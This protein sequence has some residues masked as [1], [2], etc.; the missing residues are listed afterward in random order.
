[1]K[2]AGGAERFIEQIVI[3][4]QGVGSTT[5]ALK[6][7]VLG[8]MAGKFSRL[9]GGAFGDGLEDSIV[10]TYLRLAFNYEA[11]DEIYIFGFSRGAYAVR[12]L[13]GFI[14]S[15]GIVSRRFTEK[16]WM[17][18]ALYRSAP[19]EGASEA[20][21]EAHRHATE[22]FRMLYGKGERNAD[23]THRQTSDVPKITYLG[24]FD[25][26]VQRGAS[27][28]LASLVPWRSSYKFRNLRVCPNV[29]SAR[30]AVAIDECRVG[31]PSTLWEGIDES[32]IEAERE[33]GPSPAGTYYD[34]RWFIGMHGDIGGGVGSRLA[35]AALKWIAEGAAAQGLRFY[36][37]HGADQSPLEQAIREA[38][39]WFDADITRPRLWESVQLINLP[40]RARRIWPAKAKP[41]AIDAERYLDPAALERLKAGHLRPRYRPAPLRP[42]RSVFRPP[43]KSRAKPSPEPISTG[44]GEN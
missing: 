33:R 42:L 38:E 18:F 40:F 2:D 31:F 12:A 30:H 8:D 29:L 20:D 32:N 17:G 36:A 15:V 44:G 35:A 1:V 22:Q 28:V 23:G 16:A 9:A 34:Q 39:P 14:N 26:V 27:E 24:V 4:T 7:D 13:A 3:Y 41:T 11:G 21:I 19:K 6:G 5:S 10:D 25:T 43:R 37:S